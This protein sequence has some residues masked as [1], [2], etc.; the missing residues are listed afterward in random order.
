MTAVTTS[1]SLIPAPALVLANGPVGGKVTLWH[2][3]NGGLHILRVNMRM[4]DS[5]SAGQWLPASG[6]AVPLHFRHNIGLPLCFLC[7]HVLSFVLNTHCGFLPSFAS[8]HGPVQNS[9][10]SGQ[11]PAH[12]F[13]L[14]CLHIHVDGFGSGGS[15]GYG[16]VHPLLFVM[17]SR[18]ISFVVVSPV[19]RDPCLSSSRRPPGVCDRLSGGS[20]CRR[21]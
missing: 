11:C 7:C 20:R 6:P 9:V 16:D 14:H 17:K 8:R 2:V 4:F 19:C 10:Q 1:T 15:R 5:Q 12:G 18:A 3:R 21:S 13:F